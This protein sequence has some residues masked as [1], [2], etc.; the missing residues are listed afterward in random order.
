MI[1]RRRTES[2][3]DE[4]FARLLEPEAE[5]VRELYA[6]GIVRAAWSRADVP[7][8]CLLLEAGSV[9][10]AR[11]HANRAPLIANGMIETQ[12]IPLRGYRGFHPRAPKGGS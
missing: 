10:D 5:A 2:F 6:E 3:D 11:A 12:F 8:A 7:G 9:E 1:A 4:E